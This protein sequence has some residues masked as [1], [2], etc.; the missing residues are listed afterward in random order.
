MRRWW[1]YNKLKKL[2]K[3]QILR[4]NF[5]LKILKNINLQTLK[6]KNFFNLELLRYHAF[7]K[8][9]NY[10]SMCSISSKFKKI[11]KFS[12]LNRWSLVAQLKDNN[13]PNLQ[14]F[15]W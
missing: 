6:K 3:T 1:R 4:S 10:A 5:L 12:N 11:N 2:S 7:L 9:N 8:K 15:V 13:I 14:K